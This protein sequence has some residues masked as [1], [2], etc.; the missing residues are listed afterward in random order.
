M[1]CSITRKEL[2]MLEQEYSNGFDLFETLREDLEWM[3]RNHHGSQEAREARAVFD[4]GQAQLKHLA[5]MIDMF[6]KKVELDEAL[7]KDLSD[8]EAKKN[9]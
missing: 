6:R 1:K 7:V 9:T 4:A 8:I 2:A 5:K 3:E